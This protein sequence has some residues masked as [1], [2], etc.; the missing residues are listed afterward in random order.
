MSLSNFL[1]PG[2]REDRPGSRILP[3]LFCAE[4]IQPMQSFFKMFI[5]IRD[6]RTILQPS[7]SSACPLV[8]WFSGNRHYERLASNDIQGLVGSSGEK[9]FQGTQT[10]AWKCIENIEFSTHECFSRSVASYEMLEGIL[11]QIG[12]DCDS[13][14]LEGKDPG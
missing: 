6:S 9:K 7:L 1:L 8:L 4:K 12:P 10:L 11:I 2:L 5:A 13:E 3:L 14:P